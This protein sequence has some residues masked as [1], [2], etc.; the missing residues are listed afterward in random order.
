VLGNIK[1]VQN[2]NW[3]AYGKHPAAKDYF[4]IGQESPIGKSF[5]NWVDSG[6]RGQGAI[7]RPGADPVAWRFWARG[8]GKENIVCGIVKDSCDSV[9]RHYPLLIIGT[10]SLRDWEKRWDL[11]P[12]ACDK[13]WGHIEYVSA[14]MLHD[15]KALAIEIR[16]VRQPSSEWAEFESTRKALMESLTV[17]GREHAPYDL[18]SLKKRAIGLSD[19]PEGFISLDHKS[20]HDQFA[21]ISCWHMLLKTHS[22]SVP[23]AVFIGGTFGQSFMAFFNR[24]LQTADFMH[25]WSLTS[26]GVREDGSLVSG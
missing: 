3:S 15:I 17:T 7:K 8:A 25:L 13:S 19:K 23:N 18:D 16:N 24:S 26:A 22:K 10:G 14:R 2:W 11:L 20:F 5:A 1:S 9:G 21:L 12:L 4:S 6:Y